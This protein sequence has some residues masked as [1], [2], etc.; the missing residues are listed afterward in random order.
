MSSRARGGSQPDGDDEAFHHERYAQVAHGAGNAAKAAWAR[1]AVE[2]MTSS[3]RAT[4]RSSPLASASAWAASRSERSGTTTWA[5]ASAL[6]RGIPR[7][8]ICA[9]NVARNEKGCTTRARS[10]ESLVNDAVDGGNQARKR[11]PTAA[12][13][14]PPASTQATNFGR[15]HAAVRALSAAGT[16]ETRI[17]ALQLG[18]DDEDSAVAWVRRLRSMSGS[19]PA[20]AWRKRASGNGTRGLA[21]KR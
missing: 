4:A 16:F 11:P 9:K 5:T 2:R 20:C 14:S 13:R 6:A 21:R 12:R 8:V 17:I 1:A 15:D 3:R 7:A 18:D 19:V 10:T